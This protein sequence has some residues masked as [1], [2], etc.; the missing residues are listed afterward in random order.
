MLCHKCLDNG[1]C[2]L[3][4]QSL[5]T[6][7]TWHKRALHI[8]PEGCV[9][10]P[11]ETYLSHQCKR[12][13][14][15]FLG[16]SLSKLDIITACDFNSDF[17]SVFSDPLSLVLDGRSGFNLGSVQLCRTGNMPV[18]LELRLSQRIQWSQ[19]SQITFDRMCYI[20][21]GSSQ[22]KLWPHINVSDE[23]VIHNRPFS[24]IRWH[25]TK[26]SNHDNE[27]TE[28][29]MPLGTI[30]SVLKSGCASAM[31]WLKGRANLISG[32]RK[33]WA[34]NHRKNTTAQIVWENTGLK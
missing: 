14:L 24:L 23:L 6:R 4:D 2:P 34:K 28:F 16:D 27:G 25:A 7:A 17:I 20:R 31:A 13:T 9:L 1:K 12:H 29:G 22:V 30:E 33:V 5:I 10:S 26:A 18:C 11:G 32:P 21:P 3:H 8:C 19:S 15:Q